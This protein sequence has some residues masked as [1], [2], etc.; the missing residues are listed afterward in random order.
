MSDNKNQD[1]IDTQHASEIAAIL[2]EKA[3]GYPNTRLGTYLNDA[4][5]TIILLLKDISHYHECMEPVIDSL[6]EIVDTKQY[7]FKSQQEMIGAMQKEIDEYAAKIESITK[8]RDD[9]IA[10]SELEAAMFN[11]KYDKEI[12]K[13]KDKLDTILDN[14]VGICNSYGDHG[15]VN[16]V[17]GNPVDLI[18]NLI[19]SIKERASLDAQ[20]GN[21]NLFSIVN[22]IIEKREA[23]T[24]DR[25]GDWFNKGISWQLKQFMKEMTR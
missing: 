19:G 10:L 12:K 7:E 16:G 3:L 4:S 21:A 25:F 2:S 22:D 13:L 9:A 5:A 23:F 8:Q 11:E 1:G 6:S 18:N 15:I 14:I 17:I 24:N 20:L